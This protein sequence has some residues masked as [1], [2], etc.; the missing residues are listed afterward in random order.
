MH[1][2]RLSAE[3]RNRTRNFASSIVRLF[4]TLPRRRDEVSVLAKQMLRAGT[5]VAAQLREASR[6]RSIEEFSSKVGGALQ[7]ADEVQFWLE[8][9]RDDCRIGSVELNSAHR[10]AGELV[11]ILVTILRRTR[12]RH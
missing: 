5:S 3:F 9:L 12:G 10:E 4:I 6:A 7:E 1:E 8:L 11:A 2:G